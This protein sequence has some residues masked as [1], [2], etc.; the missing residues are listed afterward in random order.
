MEE[1][2]RQ[3]CF[4]CIISMELSKDFYNIKYELLLAKSNAC[5]LSKQALK[6]SYLNNHQPKVKINKTLSSWKYLIQG[7][8]Q[9][10]V[11]GPFNIKI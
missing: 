5:G 9:G 4:A 2:S 1:N 11:L 7:V 3:K 8:A 6:F 10:P